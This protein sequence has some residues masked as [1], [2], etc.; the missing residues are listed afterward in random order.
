MKMPAAMPMTVPRSS[1][2]NF[3]LI[4]AL[5]SSISSRISSVARSEISV[6]AAAMFSGISSC[7]VAKAPQQ[8]G[9][10]HAARERSP[11]EHLRSAAHQIQA[12]RRPD[13]RRRPGVLLGGGRPVG[14]RDVA[15]FDVHSGGSSSKIRRHI[16]AAVLLE[17]IENRAPS[18]A[19]SP[20][21]ASRLTR[22][23]STTSVNQIVSPRAAHAGHL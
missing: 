13:G 17:A 1:L 5:A 12:G 9:C 6:I 11:D 16:S 14:R 18:P 22:S 7:S 4:S 20:D 19:S 3:A 23:C 2:P 10:D 8:E 21:H 15:G